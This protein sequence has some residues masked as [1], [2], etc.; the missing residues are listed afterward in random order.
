MSKRGFTL[1][2]L[3]LVL[4]LIFIV[5]SFSFPVSLSFY[6]AEVLDDAVSGLSDVLRKAQFQAVAQKNDSSFG[7]KVLPGAYVLFQGDSYGARLVSEDETFALPQPLSVAGL[8]EVLFEK[9]TGKPDA[10]R[11]I[12]VSI[13]N[14]E[15]VILINEQGTITR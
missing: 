12:T 13:Q 11:T 2:E 10:L 6:K 4:A 5:G 8:D 7:V 3:M 9:R 15:K 1:I 14:E